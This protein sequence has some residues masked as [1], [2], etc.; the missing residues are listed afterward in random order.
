MKARGD[1]G[2]IEVYGDS[3]GWARCTVPYWA[4]S[5]DA[6]MHILYSTREKS[7]KLYLNSTTHFLREK[8]DPYGGVA[9]S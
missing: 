7:H 4:Y 6:R 1:M 2:D 5:S 8:H 3:S 9:F